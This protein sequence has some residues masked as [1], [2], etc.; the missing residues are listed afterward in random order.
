MMA[1]YHTFGQG[2]FFGGV[3]FAQDS[4]TG[5]FKWGEI[6]GAVMFKYDGEPNQIWIPFP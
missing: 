6:T 2:S 1:A 3:E 5:L 4:K